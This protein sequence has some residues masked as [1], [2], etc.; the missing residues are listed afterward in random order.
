MSKGRV[1]ARCK[2]DLL[3]F[4]KVIDPKM[5]T[6]KSAPFH[7]ELAPRLIDEDTKQL[8]II[9]PRGHAKCVSGDA[10]VLLADGRRT[11]ARALEVGDRVLSYNE[12]TR[13]TEADVVLAKESS[14]K[15]ECL[16]VVTRTGRNLEVT[17]DHRVLTFSGWKRAGDLV[18]SDRIASLRHARTI[19]TETGRNDE[20]V[21]LVAYM[22]AEGSTTSGN[23]E[24]TNADPVIRDDFRDCADVL[25]FGSKIGQRYAITLHNPAGSKKS[26]GPRHWVRD[27]GLSGLA[28]EKRVPDWVFMLPARQKW[29]FLAAFVDTDGWV[30]REAGKMGITLANR[31]LIEDLRY[32]FMQVGV[33]TTIAERPND[34]A[35]AWMLQVDN[36]YLQRCAG[37]MPLLLKGDR[38]EGLL[39]KD[40]YSLVDTYPDEVKDL[41]GITR[42][43]W[44]VRH[45]VRLDN[46][47]C[48][49]RS[50][51]RR[52]L[53]KEDVPAWADLEDSDVMWDEIVSIE[54][55]G[56][57]DTFDFQ[58]GKN[59]N[60][61]TEGLVTHNSTLAA[62]LL[63]L[64]HIMFHEGPKFVVLVS[65]TLGHA[66]DLLGSIKNTLDHSET[67]KALFGYWGRHSAQ[68]WQRDEIILKDGT[69][70]L[71]R[72]STQ[73]MRGLKH[74]NQRPT[75]VVYDDPQDEENTKTDDA[76]NNALDG[77]LKGIM[78][79]LD[80]LRGRVIVIG[81]P[82]HERGI[83][84]ILEDAED[85]E[86]LKYWAL[87]KE[88]VDDGAFKPMREEEHLY[89]ALWPEIWPVEKLI[90][91][92]ESREAM[93]K[94]SSFYS[95][96]QSVIVGDKDQLFP[97]T[98]FRYWEGELKRD[99]NRE[100]YLVIT[101][102]GRPMQSLPEP[103]R[104]PVNLFM[105]VDPASSTS[106]TADYTCIFVIAMDAEKNVYCIDCWR[107]RAKPMQV[108]EAIR[109]L[110]KRYRPKKTQIETVGYQEMLRQYLREE[111]P[112]YIPG[113]EIKN[114][115]RRGKTERLESLQ[116]E[117]ALG[118]VYI[119]PL[120]TAFMDELVLFPRAKNDDTLDAFYYARK[121][122][123]RP[124]H[125]I[126]DKKPEE[127]HAQPMVDWIADV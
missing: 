85:W 35:G 49:T 92:Y 45:G 6:V 65:K 75:L 22:L 121:G 86:T 1:I 23:C 42:H 56:L 104:L 98:T 44:R 88:G 46:R 11:P 122:A 69:R 73:Q 39:Q 113:L 7:Y 126:T 100:H 71:C 21:R 36:E 48:V 101:H 4:G 19:P 91:T 8:N 103:K 127:R 80:A 57:C 61:I 70:L 41:S 64:H 59:Q 95:E 102:K 43:R 47:H 118:K 109:T 78:P 77:L 83:V 58:V 114:N 51:I 60:F 112:E 72:S 106:R 15:K 25:G 52:C 63:P 119:K 66:R 123:Y 117:F 37:H 24:F 99:E 108:A 125:D 105:G 124:Y 38:L 2:E 93:G 12:G 55:I 74:I 31:P 40:R 94:T 16:S 10:E 89:S 107:Q 53:E 84:N 28:T 67:F 54:R 68:T 27:H 50:K 110:Y 120:M 14:G 3:F 29:L 96:Y 13:R 76:L 79:G 30:A 18:S 20:E 32:L 9:A 34:C 81:T 62:N 82:I 5:F 90:Q 17:P 26:G 33:V 116:P 87:Y 115:P 97:E 111:V